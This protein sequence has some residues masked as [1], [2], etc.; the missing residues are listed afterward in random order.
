MFRLLTALPVAAAMALTLPAG[1]ASLVQNGGFETV[2]SASISEDTNIA[3]PS[4]WTLGT[5]LSGCKYDTSLLDTFTLQS[6]YFANPTLGFHDIQDSTPGN[7]HFISFATTPGHSPDGGNAIT[8][9]AKTQ[10]GMLLQ[11]ITGLVVGAT[12][13][14][15]F[16]QAS[17]QQLGYSGNFTADWQVS[18]GT[19]VQTSATMNNPSRGNTGWTLQNLLFKA[20]STSEVLG[21][22]AQAGEG[23]APPF[24][25]LDGVSLTQVPEPSST[26]LFGA[27][28]LMTLGLRR[29]RAIGRS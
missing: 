19:D 9:E 27:A 7:D 6:D 5:C 28:L 29:R 26:A 25:L 8:A 14:L 2:P 17:A 12:Y 3:T 1:A 11:T 24:V 21:F 10:V 22:L 16:Y 23:A 4:G 18:F 15:S 20:S 13:N